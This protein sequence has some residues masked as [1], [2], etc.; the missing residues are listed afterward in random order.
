MYELL[1]AL[2]S[3]PSTNVLPYAGMPA[4]LFEGFRQK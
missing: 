1:V 4:A 3:H 2:K